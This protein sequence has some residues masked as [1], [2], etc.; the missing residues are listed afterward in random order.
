MSASPPVIAASDPNSAIEVIPVRDRYDLDAFL[1]VPHALYRDDPHWIAPLYMERRQALSERNPFFRHARWRAWLACADGQPIGRIS[2]Q[3]DQLHLD[4][5]QDATGFFGSIEAPDRPEVFHALF[6]HAERWLRDNG[7]R[8][9]RGPFNL[10][11]NQESGLL[12]EG[13][14]SPPYVMMGHARPWYGSHIEA[15]GYRG[16]MDLL[17]YQIAVPYTPSTALETLRKRFSGRIRLRPFDRRRAREDL[18]VLRDIFNDAWSDN[19]SFVPYTVEEFQA[20][21]K[22]LLLLVP[23][24]FIQIAE[25]GGEPA[26]F[27][28]VL[29]NVNEAIA[30]LGGRLLPFGWAKLLWRLKVRHPRSV[31]TP[32]MGVRRKY[33]GSPLGPTL[34]YSVIDAALAPSLARGVERAELSWILEDNRDMR[35]IIERIGGV[36]SKRYRMYDKDLAA[37]A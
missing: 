10:N 26:A 35:R 20:M 12:V 8:R 21:G 3:I 22:E 13:F 7:M 11:I 19:W 1:S 36:V 14:D 34:A 24:G 5:Y 18:E 30:D 23:D 28:V 31:R 25:V 37:D 29:P 9:A 6:E 32:L 33:H 15:L 16:A 17:A 2:A 4:R 27:M